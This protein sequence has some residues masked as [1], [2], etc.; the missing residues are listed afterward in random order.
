MD[1]CKICLGSGKVKIELFYSVVEDKCEV[2]DGTGKYVELCVL[3]KKRKATASLKGSV[4]IEY[5][6]SC[7]PKVQEKVNNEEKEK[8]EQERFIM[9]YLSV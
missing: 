3:C 7:L 6:F 1:K 5:C 4:K 2:C 9:K 8:L